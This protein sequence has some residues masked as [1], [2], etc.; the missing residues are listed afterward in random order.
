M[1]KGQSEIQ[2]VA[3]VCTPLHQ[4]GPL[5]NDAQRRQVEGFMNGE[6]ESARVFVTK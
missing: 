5:F 2:K 4:H 3:Y 1:Y 6:L